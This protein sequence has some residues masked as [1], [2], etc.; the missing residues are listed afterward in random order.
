MI[1][2]LQII[3]LI[4]ELTMKGVSEEGAITSMCNKYEINK[5]T[6]RKFL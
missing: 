4:L 3:I 5:E 2:I 6:I 1:Q